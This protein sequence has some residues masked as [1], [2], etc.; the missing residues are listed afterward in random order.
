M[1]SGFTQPVDFFHFPYDLHRKRFPAWTCVLHPFGHTQTQ[2]RPC[3]GARLG[4]FLPDKTCRAII[5]KSRVEGPLLRENLA[6]LKII[7][8]HLLDKYVFCQLKFWFFNHSKQVEPFLAFN[9]LSGKSK[10]LRVPDNNDNNDNNTMTMMPMTWSWGQ[11]S[12]WQ[13]C[14]WWFIW[15]E[16]KGKFWRMQ[17]I[18]N[19]C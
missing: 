4:L 6:T 7:R 1:F 11:L 16:W 8:I 2:C 17:G 9:L 19:E 5:H 13:W 3:Y 15:N 12:S 18:G 14:S 10:M